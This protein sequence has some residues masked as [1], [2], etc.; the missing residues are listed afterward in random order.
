MTAYTQMR[1]EHERVND[2]S[3]KF[4]KGLL[5]GDS[6][7]T[8]SIENKT[9]LVVSKNVWQ[10]AKINITNLK[11]IGIIFKV[12]LPQLSASFNLLEVTKRQLKF[13]I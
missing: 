8:S 11:C 9:M 10:N 4:P 7:F 1:Y 12:N 6:Q 13:L 3:M 2:H 5:A